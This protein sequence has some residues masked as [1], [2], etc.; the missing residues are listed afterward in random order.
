MA[1]PRHNTTQLPRALREELGLPDSRNDRGANRR[2][3][4]RKEVRKALRSQRRERH[5]RVAQKRSHQ[6]L[7]KKVSKLEP[8]GGEENEDEEESDYAERRKGKRRRL[9]GEP[10][11]VDIDLDESDD[12][13]EDHIEEDEEQEKETSAQPLRHVPQSVQEKFAEDDAEIARL[14]KLLGIKGRKLPKSFTEDGLDEL[15]DDL[16]AG[17]GYDDE[18]SRKREEDEWLAEKRRKAQGHLHQKQSSLEESS[19]DGGLSEDDFEGFDSEAEGDDMQSESG[20][21]SNSGDER[22]TKKEKTRAREN[23]YIA[24]VTSSTPASQ[25]YIP[26]SLRVRSND[27]SEAMIRLRRQAQGHLNKLSD[28]NLVSILQQFEAL[29]NEHP[30]QDV[31]TT[32]INLLFDLIYTSSFLQGSFIILHAGFITAMYRVIGMDFGAELLQ[33]LVERFDADYEA[34]S[35]TFDTES[36]DKDT[37]LDDPRRKSMVNAIS[38]LSHLYNFHMIGCGLVFDYIK[39]F[40]SPINGMNTEF[41]LKIIR[42]SGPQLRSDDP[43]S[44]KDI[45]LLIQPAVARIGEENLHTRT[46]FMIEMITQLKNNRMK[47]GAA[48]SLDISS[49]HVTRLRK[50]LGALNNSRTIRATEPLRIGRDDIRDSSKKGKWWLVGASWHSNDQA[51]TDRPQP[52]SQSNTQTAA[53]PIKIDDDLGDPDSVDLLQLARS[54]RMNTDVRRSIFVALLSASDYR[55]AHTRLVT[56][57]LK[58]KQQA[59]IPRV[60]LHC[61]SEE[62]AYNPYY[63]LIARQLCSDRRLKMSFMFA[64]WDIFKRMGEQTDLDEDAEYSEET[65]DAVNIKAIVNLAKMFAD[66]ILNGHLTLGILKVLNFAYLQEKTKMFVEVLLVTVILETYKHKKSIAFAGKTAA[67]Q[68]GK[69]LEGK[70]LIDVF[71]K[72]RETPQIA[73]GLIY[74]LRQVVSKTDVVTSKKEMTA[75]KTGSKVALDTL[76]TLPQ[77]TGGEK[78]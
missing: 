12:V 63:T 50:A 71:A 53:A 22:F 47:S 58:R 38:L 76:K 3:L 68:T 39:L 44:L 13:L 69:N 23:P 49:E 6:P 56:L 43:S 41:L 57:H 74:F 51:I 45:V 7:S 5:S 64:L 73:T 61:A 9:E 16:P 29:Y 32:V 67:S 70:A 2:P 28:A 66:L 24:P 10:F 75:V 19:A 36:G 54:H 26:P 31:T 62:N 27:E 18:K 55:D 8:E 65:G 25:K 33:R 4:Y 59:E 60:L 14:E 34:A 15:L 35:E 40:L 77:P 21:E 78:S 46:K 30:R 17:L 72:V 42:N 52:D 37:G 11:N 20:L 48:A 1:P